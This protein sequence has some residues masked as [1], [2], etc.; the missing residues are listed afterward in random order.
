MIVM[1]SKYPFYTMMVMGLVLQAE[2]DA[3]AGP[4]GLETIAKAEPEAQEGATMMGRQA[5]ELML[6]GQ[7][8]AALHAFKVCF[9]SP[10]FVLPHSA[11]F[12]T[13]TGL[14]RFLIRKNLIKKNLT[15]LFR[16]NKGVAQGLLSSQPRTKTNLRT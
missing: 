9:L 7:G 16:P 10:L 2:L 6:S 3:M 12:T 15:R 8:Q 4:D 13:S 14:T 11:H 1:Y 5:R